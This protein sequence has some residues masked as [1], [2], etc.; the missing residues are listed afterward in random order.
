VSDVV[1][2]D[3]VEFPRWTYLQPEPDAVG[4]RCHGPGLR[5]LVAAAQ[6]KG[7][8]RAAVFLAHPAPAFGWVLPGYAVGRYRVLARV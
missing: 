1:P 5:G 7:F 4:G 2:G 3:M 6:P 8:C